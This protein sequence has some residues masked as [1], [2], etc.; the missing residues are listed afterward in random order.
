MDPEVE[1]ISDTSLRRL[2]HASATALRRTCESLNRDAHLEAAVWQLAKANDPGESLS[3][4]RESSP[5]QAKKLFVLA[6]ASM[7]NSRRMLE[8][9]QEMIRRGLIQSPM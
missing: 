3:Q 6:I 9:E 2:S 8:C 5:D 4:L 1:R 7:V